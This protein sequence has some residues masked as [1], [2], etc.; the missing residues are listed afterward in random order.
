MTLEQWQPKSLTI[1]GT[2]SLFH[3][4]EDVFRELDR[5]FGE[6]DRVF[7][8]FLTDT[9][10]PTSYSLPMELI[11]AKDRFILRLE[12][13]GVQK[14]DISVSVRDG[15]LYIKAERRADEALTASEDYRTTRWY[16]QFR[17]AITIP[18][19][20]DEGNLEARYENGILE[21]VFPK[22]PEY[23]GRQIPVR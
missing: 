10:I 2:P 16:G 4:V 12:L 18:S 23:E 11:E 14:E 21:I 8:R 22:R 5:V 6:I 17:K 9:L 13:P 15:V 3:Q 7:E 1:R 19:Y 20:I